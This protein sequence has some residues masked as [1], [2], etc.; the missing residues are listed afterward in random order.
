MPNP[1]RFLV[2]S[3]VL[4]LFSGVVRASALSVIEE[5]YYEDYVALFPI[6]ATANGD[7]DRRYEAVFPNDISAEHRGQEAAMARKYLQ[8][9]A[10]LDRSKLDAV[11]LLDYEILKWSLDVRLAGLD[12]PT[13]LLPVNQFWGAPLLFAQMGSGASLHPFKTEQDYRNFIA[14][15]KGFS[16]WVDTAIANMREGVAK[17]LVQPRILMERTLPQYEPLMADDAKKNIFFAPLKSLPTE[18]SAAD[19]DQLRSDYLAAIH[20]IIIPAYARLH[21]FIKNEYLPRCR[22]T[23]GIGAMPGGRE[24]YAYWI[25]FWTTT[26][27]TPEEI[28]Q[29]GLS[30]VTRIHQEMVKVMGDVGF[31]GTL[32]EFITFVAKDPQ[33]APFTTSEQVLDAYR[34]IEAKLTP[35]L[36]KFFGHLPRSKFEIRETEKFRAAAASAEYQPASVDGTRP[37]IFYVPIVDPKMIRTPEMEDLFLHEAIP[38]HHFQFSLSLEQPDLPKFRRFGWTSAFSE[39]WALYTESMGKELGVYQ[40]PYSYYGMLLGELHR[41]VRL[42]VDTGIHAKGWSREKA[43]AYRDEQEGVSP[44]TASEIERYMAAPAQ[45]LSYKLG[46]LKFLELRR[47][48]EKI[49]GAKFD[50]RAFHDKILAEGSVPLAVLEF[51][52]NA[53]IQDQRPER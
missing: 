37:G 45:A 14:R 28:H 41:A 18:L 30:E 21:S 44:K 43:I 47:R 16:A 34:D 53:W 29:L 5:N 27:R 11:E 32:P 23:A 48:A 17:G 22:D 51:R 39:G 50:I 7:S 2:G 31:K 20:T 4:L 52:V 12:Q 3:L 46:Q 1:T 19:T 35:S 10:A 8:Q 38:G 6:D 40:N 15:A 24:M 25:R 49:L 42:V 13:H 26:D 36:P 9:L 33:F